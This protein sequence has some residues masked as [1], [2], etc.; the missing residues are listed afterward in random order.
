MRYA[1]LALLLA[2]CCGATSASGSSS[3]AFCGRW[4]EARV[5]SV[6]QVR[7]GSWIATYELGRWHGDRRFPKQHGPCYIYGVS[8]E[9]ASAAAAET[10][11]INRD[12]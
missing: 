7:G 5:L 4:P 10:V 3:D 11:R 8:R 2:G 12:E 1:L 9:E 6:V